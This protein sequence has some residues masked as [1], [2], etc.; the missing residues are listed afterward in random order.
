MRK[1][2]QRSYLALA[3]QLIVQGILLISSQYFLCSQRG[4]RR[5]YPPDGIGKSPK[6]LIHSSREFLYPLT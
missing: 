5:H 6:K 3:A 1:I 2:V 4:R